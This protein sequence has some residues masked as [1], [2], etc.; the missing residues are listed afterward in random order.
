MTRIL[1]V[2]DKPEN[3]YLLQAMLDSSDFKTIIAKNGAEALGLLRNNMPDLIISDILMPVMDGFA[4]CKECKKD[5]KL[6]KIPF[7]F[8]TATY[9]DTKDETYALSLG[10]DRFILKPQEPD[11][12]L[13]IVNDFLDDVKNKTIQP[14]EIIQPSET[15]VLKEY[16]EVL[17]RKIEDKM[18]QAQKA[19]KDLKSYSEKL[20]NEIRTR[21]EKEEILRKSEEYNRLLF[22]KSPIGLAL[23]RMDGSLVDINPAF[24]KILGR[25]VEETLKLSYWDITPEKY[26]AQKEEQL[27]NLKKTGHYGLYEK[28]YIHKDGHLVPVLLQGLI[29]ERGGESFIWSS[30]EDI[31]ERKRLEVTQE[32]LVKISNA[33][34]SSQDIETFFRFIFTELKEIINTSNFYIALYDEKSQMISTPFISDQLD[35]SLIDFPV[36]K[37]MT[38]YVIKNKKSMLINPENMADLIKKGLV[39]MVG[40][41]SEVWIGVP[42]FFKESVTGAIV[43]Q[44]Y[45]GEKKL[46]N[47]DLKILEYV[48]P[49]ISLAIERKK[50]LQALKTAYEKAKES[51]RLKTAFLNNISHEIRTPLNGILG[52]APFIIEPNISQNEKEQYLNILNQGCD[53]LL[54][55]ITSY[56]DISMIVSESIEVKY[57]F[58]DL[59]SIFN[60]VYGYFQKPSI[61]KNLKL[62]INLPDEATDFGFK[63]DEDLFRKIL[64]HI[65]D[66]AVKYTHKGFIEFGFSLKSNLER[67]EVEFFVKDTGKGISKRAQKFVFN[68]FRQEDDLNTTAHEGNGLGLSIAKGIIE[69]LGGNI[70]LESEENIGTSVYFSIPFYDKDIEKNDGEIHSIN[71]SEK[72]SFDKKIKLLIAEDQDD[73]YQFLTLIVKKYS[74][75][76]LRAT[77]GKEAVEIYRN[78]PDIDLI[79]MDIKMPVLNGYEATR[80]IRELSK[81]VIIIAQTAFGLAGDREKAIEAGCN[82]YIAKPIDKDLLIEKI[83]KPYI[84]Q[85]DIN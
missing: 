50:N 72:S 41:P 67:P 39:E 70:R 80:Q 29:I 26:A 28:E 40:P 52:F 16:N 47:E 60:E 42:L 44:N 68:Y 4:L 73:S 6:K 25:T 77:T 9:T 48:A 30:V 46:G 59:P 23:C 37:T 19:E 78:N 58:I 74:S 54:R 55:T 27:K 17:I 33:V 5:E 84:S 8:Y 62:K 34:L 61:E 66:N 56:M 18:L 12:F 14:K 82:N 7:F 51:D 24:A 71:P 21:Q 3:L 35:E 20:E 65:V 53:R 10:A 83:I 69:L 32:A 1:I 85:M 13:K 57:K 79:F 31:T 63:T 2:D 45:E 76:I 81:N 75:E 64:M 11:D 15:I 43:M 22:N 49:S 38:G 36:G